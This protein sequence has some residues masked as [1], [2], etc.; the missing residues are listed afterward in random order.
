M[1]TEEVSTEEL[2]KLF[3][4]FLRTYKD[5]RNN[6]VYWKSLLRLSSEET[7][8]SVDFG[9]LVRFEPFFMQLITENPELFFQIADRVLRSL[10]LIEKKELVEDIGEEIRVRLVNFAEEELHKDMRVKLRYIRSKHIGRL[11]RVDGIMMRASEVKPLLVN[12]TFQC[13]VCMTEIPQEQEEGRYTE[14]AQCFTCGKKTPMKLLLE[15]SRFIDWQKVRIQERPEE[16]PAGQ[17]P[18]SV[19]AVL[20]GDIVDISRPGDMVKITGLLKTTPDFTRR[21]GRLATFR[22]FIEANSVAIA[23]K[24]YELQE[25]SPEDR[26]KI[27]KL[28]KDPF[29]HKR[30]FRSIAPSIQGHD[31]VKESIALLL[32]GGGDRPLPGGT[33]MRGRSNIL[34]IGDPGTGKSQILKFVAGLASRGLY[35][36]GKGTTAAGLTAAVVHETDTGAMTLE[37]GALVLADQGI[38]C[39]D[40]FDKMDPNDRTAIHEAMEQHTVSIAKAGIVAT[41]NA[42]TSILAAANP[43][44]GRYNINESLQNNTRLPVTILSRFDLVW[45]MIDTVDETK[46]RRLAEFILRMVQDQQPPTEDEVAPIDPDLLK[47]YISH[48]ISLELRPMLSVEA[49]E[50]IENYYVETRA[51]APAGTIPITARQLESL[52]RLAEARA[53]MALEDEVTKEDAQASVKLMEA[54]LRMVATDPISGL[55]DWDS[56]YAPMGARQRNLSEVVRRTVREL[57]D[58]GM[59]TID[60]EDLIQRV[61]AATSQARESIEEVIKKLVNEGV[62][63]SPRDGKIRRVQ[64]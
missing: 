49:A 8:L 40:E 4:E 60:E 23:E 43:I 48:A 63:Y 34:M 56:A 57:E 32:F 58:E 21:G 59:T 10:L 55:V 37:A 24:E 16:L 46:D 35:T 33:Q 27:D 14:P 36:S 54:S 28:S 19:D 61:T 18:R 52:V 13:R 50:E 45:I 51:N 47:K 9:D 17:M 29:V 1:T 42:R 44:L 7:S 2:E 6:E 38:A 12:A 20:M 5:T 53:R 41:L 11:I 62:L 30:I 3:E 26:E 31:L 64:G 15:R 39:I 25:L 22:V